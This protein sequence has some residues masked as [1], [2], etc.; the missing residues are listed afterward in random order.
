MSINIKHCIKRGQ[1][2]PS[3]GQSPEKPGLSSMTRLE[4]EV[5]LKVSQRPLP[6]STSLCTTPKAVQPPA[7]RWGQRQLTRGQRFVTTR[8]DT[9][10]RA[11]VLTPFHG[12]PES[13]PWATGRARV[14]PLLPQLT[15]GRRQLPPSRSSPLTRT[16]RRPWERGRRDSSVGDSR[17]PTTRR[18][19]RGSATFPSS[20]RDDAVR[21]SRRRPPPWCP[22]HRCSQAGP[23]LLRRRLLN[24]HL[25]HGAL[26]P[27]LH[28][29]K[30]SPS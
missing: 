11:L 14:A 10:T 7:C 4:Q 15:A 22:C 21:P 26:H 18:E 8:R 6:T 28:C 5:G 19:E 27:R 13:S 29:Q 1:N 23:H 20:P 17:T 12:R 2:K 24:H 25:Q 16:C 30:R 9:S 3:T